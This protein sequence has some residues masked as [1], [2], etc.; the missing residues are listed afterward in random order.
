MKQELPA[1]LS[2]TFPKRKADINKYSAGTVAVVGGSIR[3]PHAPVI[4]AIGAKAAGAG[5]IHLVAPN[6]SAFAAGTHVPEA[7]VARLSS[8]CSIPKADV[9]AAGMGLGV[10]GKSE[11][12]VSKLISGSQACF[13]LDADALN[14]L[15]KWY[16][17]GK[18]FRPVDNQV[19]VLTPHE[20]EAARL[21]GVPSEDISRNR[22]AA[23][24]SISGRFG[25]VTVLKGPNTIVAVPAQGK[26]EGVVFYRC[27]AGNPYM[28]VGGMGD[29]LAG[30][31][32]A[33]WAYLRKSCP[34]VDPRTC[35]AKA[36]SSAV[37]LHASSADAVLESGDDAPGVLS[38]AR[39]AAVSR[40]KLENFGTC[41]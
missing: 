28:A 16:G 12:I 11:M 2:G 29:L 33:R 27:E 41:R 9:T 23:A 14:I 5:L 40:I 39:R 38:V 26:S 30:M 18:M 22:E 4:A 19:L 17:S 6:V 21:L 15:A 36:A 13:V 7:T 32:A 1:L 24:V 3:F 25:A 37:W 34:G 35:A 31:I 10:S 8:T 20:G